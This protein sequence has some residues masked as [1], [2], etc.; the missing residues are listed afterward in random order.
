[1]WPVFDVVYAAKGKTLPIA[2]LGFG[3]GPC[4]SSITSATLTNVSLSQNVQ[5]SCLVFDIR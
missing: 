5:R 2:A 4:G 1:M 3:G